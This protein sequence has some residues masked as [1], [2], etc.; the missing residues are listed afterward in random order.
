MELKE[1]WYTSTLLSIYLHVPVMHCGTLYMA[2]SVRIQIHIVELK[3][4]SK[5]LATHIFVISTSYQSRLLNYHCYIC[6][7]HNGH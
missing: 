1:G 6:Y 5:L 3:A 7:C 2:H 4:Y